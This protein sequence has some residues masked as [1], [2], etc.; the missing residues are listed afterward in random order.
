MSETL[1][2]S[3]ALLEQFANREY[4]HGWSSDVESDTFA[5]GLNEDVVRRIS[6]KK[7]EPGW[8]LDWRL[9]AYRHFL[10]MREP[11]WPN[12]HYEPVDLQSISYYS[13]PKM[14]PLLDSLEDADPEILKT[15][16]KLGIPVEEQKVLLNVKGAASSAADAL[17]PGLPMGG[18][19]VDAVFDSVSVVTTFK[20]EL[21]KL[22]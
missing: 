17:S 20:K 1:D 6:A 22:G 19:A 7:G 8:L 18:V 11:K 2:Q 9:K 21:A 5:P 16:Q 3:T 14:K 4:E 15:F 10:T 13:A 12:V